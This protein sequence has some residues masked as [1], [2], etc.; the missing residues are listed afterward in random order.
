MN[1]TIA[2]PDEH[3]KLVATYMRPSPQSNS[4]ARAEWTDLTD[5]AVHLGLENNTVLILGDLNASMNAPNTR[6]FPS[7]KESSGA[8]LIV[9]TKRGQTGG[10]F[11]LP[12]P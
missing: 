8:P 10:R 1:I 7:Q 2:N 4:Q 6:R 12:T 9:T 5:Y 11:S 3:I